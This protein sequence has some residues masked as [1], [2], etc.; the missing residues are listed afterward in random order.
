MFDHDFWQLKNQKKEIT[1][2]W[3]YNNNI[4]DDFAKGYTKNMTDYWS[5]ELAHFFPTQFAEE[6]VNDLLKKAYDSGFSSILVFKQGCTLRGPNFLSKF[7]KF[8]N[9]NAGVK[10]I[11]HILD[12]E[13]AYYEIHPQ[14]FFIDLKWWAE[15]GFPE[16]GER[17]V[18]LPFETLEPVRS[19]ENHHDQYTP[20][21][22]CPPI[23]KNLKT[24]QGPLGEGWNM[25][26]SLIESGQKIISWNKDCRIS[27]Q[28]AYAEVE[29]DAPRHRASLLEEV[30]QE[31]S[32]FVANTENVAELDDFIRGRMHERPDWDG[33]FQQVVT[34]ASGIST[35]VYAFKLGLKAGDTIIIYDISKFAI[36]YTSKLIKK[37]D[38][39]TSYTKFVLEQK[40]R[41]PGNYK[42]IQQLSYTEELINELNKEGFSEWVNND[43]KKI[44]II[45]TEID[46]YNQPEHNNF[47]KDIDPKLMTFFHFTNIFHY[48]PL[49]FYYSLK[50][51]WQL[52]NDLI[53][54]IKN[55]YSNNNNALINLYR[56]T[57]CNSRTFSSVFWIDHADTREFSEI[58]EDNIFRLLKWNK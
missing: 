17:D 40:E 14:T 39:S 51:K 47:F 46:L 32:C 7:R 27:K 25:V 55:K 26:K 8:L 18:D 30:N 34:P 13:E 53:N 16:W 19:E 11:G 58:S 43:L 31:K 28:Y 10:F 5:V 42:G 37:W 50:Q 49:S 20:L 15:A 56:G 29:V 44:N 57:Y 4:K 48:M 35:L 24:Y 3:L 23:T 38:A 6:N 22:I 9:E 52:S 12:R 54:K 45:K 1:V 2:G 33:S 36:E 21:W 41:T